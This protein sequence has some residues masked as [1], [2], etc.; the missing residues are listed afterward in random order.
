MSIGNALAVAVGCR[1][2]LC[3]RV[4][5]RYMDSSLLVKSTVLAV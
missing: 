4:R 3:A 2:R 5:S 1:L